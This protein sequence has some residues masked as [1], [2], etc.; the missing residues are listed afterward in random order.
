[1]PIVISIISSPMG[2]YIIIKGWNIVVVNPAM[3]MVARTIPSAFPW[4]PPPTIPE[5]EVYINV[6]V[7]VNIRF[8][9]HD[10]FYRSSMKYYGWW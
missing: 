7:D 8:R 9:Y 5:K 6:R 3:I 10:H 1:M 2:I 4:S